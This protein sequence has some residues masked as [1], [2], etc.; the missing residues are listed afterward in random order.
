MGKLKKIDERCPFDVGMNLLGGKW[1]MPILWHLSRGAVRFNELQR[2]L[3]GITQHVLTLQLRGLERDGLVSRR[4]YAE[5]PPKV[6]YS[7][8][9]QGRGVRPVFDALCQW[10]RTYRGTS[11]KPEA[12]E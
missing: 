11:G 8:T 6:E 12:A 5:V 9:E 7:L 10:G 1:R 4:I 2:R 3:P